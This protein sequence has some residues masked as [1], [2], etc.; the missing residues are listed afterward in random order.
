MG[1]KGFP[2]AV[3]YYAD[4]SAIFRECDIFIPAA[5]EQTVNRVIIYNL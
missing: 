1:I 3:D 4:E 5:F 2:K